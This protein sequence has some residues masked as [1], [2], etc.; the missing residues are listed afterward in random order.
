MPIAALAPL[1]EVDLDRREAPVTEFGNLRRTAGMRH[2]HLDQ[3]LSAVLSSEDHVRD[4]VTEPLL[5]FGVFELEYAFP[6]G[7]KRLLADSRADRRKHEQLLSVQH[8]LRP[9]VRVGFRALTAASGIPVVAEMRSG[10]LAL[11]RDQG[12]TAGRTGACAGEP[13]RYDCDVGERSIGTLAIDQLHAEGGESLV[14]RVSKRVWSAR[15]DGGG[16]G[17]WHSRFRAA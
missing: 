15:M 17:R 16:Y 6:V 4:D 3:H 14:I 7:L 5:E 13:T 9:D 12:A 8:L 10:L 2:H 11:F 1:G